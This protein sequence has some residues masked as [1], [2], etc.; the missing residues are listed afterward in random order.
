MLQANSPLRLAAQ[1]K[2]P[3]LLAHGAWDVRV[4]I[5]HGEKMRDA[6]KA[7]GHSQVDWVVYP[8]E[9]HGWSK[10]ET[11]IDFWTRVEK[12]LAQHIGAA[13]AK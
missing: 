5:V 10:L 8:E 12:F 11:N 13:A 4:P 6:L 1:L 9:A 7:A 2:A 3:L